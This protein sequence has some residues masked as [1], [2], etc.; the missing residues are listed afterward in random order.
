MPSI[1]KKITILDV[2]AALTLIL[3]GIVGYL[4]TT[5]QNQII[6]VQKEI[7]KTMN[8]YNV[9]FENHDGRITRNAEDIQELKI[10]HTNIRHGLKP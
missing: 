4:N 1:S 9:K 10:F 7:L 2:F 3:V 5:Q 8:V 6:S